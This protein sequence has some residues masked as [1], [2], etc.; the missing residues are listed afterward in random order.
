M[1]I[2]VRSDILLTCN[3][4]LVVRIESDLQDMV[5][6]RVRV[7]VKVRVRIRVICGKHKRRDFNFYMFIVV[8]F[9]IKIVV[10]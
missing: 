5:R 4:S 1:T 7:R 8:F 6:V 3:L 2:G 10:N 9:L